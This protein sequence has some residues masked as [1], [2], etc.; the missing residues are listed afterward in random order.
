MR[1]DSAAMAGEVEMSKQK[2]LAL[3]ALFLVI[4]V[5]VCGSLVLTAREAHALG[6]HQ[7]D[8]LATLH[9]PQNA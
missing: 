6:G 9:V 5:F 7:S 3:S 1:I 2:R 8:W 4:S